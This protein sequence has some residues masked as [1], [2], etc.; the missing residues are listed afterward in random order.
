MA[1]SALNISSNVLFCC[2]FRA[3]GRVL[4]VGNGIHLDSGMVLFPIC[5]QVS[6]TFRHGEYS[7]GN[8]IDKR[9]ARREESNNVHGKCKLSLIKTN[10]TMS[11]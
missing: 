8:D 5:L 6:L 4:K 3:F 10:S 2:A 11:R 1:S 9:Y 7:Y